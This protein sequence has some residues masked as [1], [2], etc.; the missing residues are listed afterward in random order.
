MRFQTGSMKLSFAL[1]DL[2]FVKIKINFLSSS[3]SRRLQKEKR[4]GK[5]RKKGKTRLLRESCLGLETDGKT[6]PRVKDSD[7]GSTLA[8]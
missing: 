5:G 1:V 7:F 6:D 2:K 8:S 3:S 4:G